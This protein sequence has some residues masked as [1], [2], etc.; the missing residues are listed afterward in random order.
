MTFDDSN[1]TACSYEDITFSQGN[2]E[3]AETQTLLT[4]PQASL[5]S[6]H[7]WYRRLLLSAGK[8]NETERKWETYLDKIPRMFEGALNIEFV[9]LLKK[10]RQQLH[11]FIGHVMSPPDAVEGEDG[12]VQLIWEKDNL[13]L[14]VD[15]ISSDNIEWFLKDRNTKENWGDEE[16]ALSDFP[17]EELQKKLKIWKKS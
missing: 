12:G 15:V 9:N 7:D 4:P 8:E 13:Y 16:I 1:R 5:S 2:T 14:A 3:V 10:I 17:P 11:D 6:I